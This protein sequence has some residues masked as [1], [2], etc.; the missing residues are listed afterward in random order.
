MDESD[1]FMSNPVGF[2]STMLENSS[3]PSH[4][5]MFESEEKHLRELLVSHSYKEVKTIV[6]SVYGLC[7]THHSFYF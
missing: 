4:L 1:R 6:R 7:Y 2:V 5:V 3:L